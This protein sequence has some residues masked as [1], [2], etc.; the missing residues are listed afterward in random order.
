MSEEN[1]QIKLIKDFIFDDNLQQEL[2]EIN[3]NLMAFNIFEITGMGHQEIKHST[4]LGWLFDDSEHNLEYKILD[5]FL[6]KV[7]LKNEKIETLK[8]YIYLSHKQDLNIYREKD[9]IDLLVVDENNKVVI[10]IENK[11]FA[12]ERKDG[13]DGGQLQKYKDII[14]EKYNDDYQKYFIF[15]TMNLD[16]PSEGNKNWMIANH[17][18]V[19]DTIEEII[20]NKENLSVKTKI[21][22]E[23][24]VDLLKKKKIVKDAKL[25]RICN[26]LWKDYK[27]ELNLIHELKKEFENISIDKKLLNSLTILMAYKP[28]MNIK[29]LDIKNEL[30][31]V[32]IR[33]IND[34]LTDNIGIVKPNDIQFYIKNN[35]TKTTFVWIEDNK[36]NISMNF[37]QLKS[38]KLNK[39]EKENILNKYNHIGKFTNREFI[40]KINNESEINNNLLNLIEDE[41]TNS[42]NKR[43]SKKFCVNS[44][45]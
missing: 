36:N 6:K 4:I 2:S 9:N 34:R 33:K 24:Y 45:E 5:E 41:M 40:V 10:T 26:Q 19:T 13:E 20:K 29:D 11:I 35:I 42:I 16:Q 3:N 21:I 37:N 44:I 43:K 39:E 1:E 27:N 22:F 7:I 15:L 17:Q 8:E 25:D 32:L 12:T 38:S 23:S 28:L 14:D 18:M 31:K 30:L